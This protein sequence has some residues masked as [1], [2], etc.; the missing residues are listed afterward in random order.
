MIKIRE[1][2]TIYYI[3]ITIF[4]SISVI[5]LFISLIISGYKHKKSMKNY[6]KLVNGIRGLNMEELL[7]DINGEVSNINSQID[8]II[9]NMESMN[10]RL[11][12]SIQNIGFVRYNAFREMGSELSFSIALLDEYKNGLVYSSI[13]GRDNAVSYGKPIKNG[14]SRIPLSA[15]EILALDRAIKR[16]NL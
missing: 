2:I 4:L 8:K 15:E 1:L 11:S 3:E 10:T 14:T 12:F 6:Y 13:Y 5:L 16:E 7:I 9:K